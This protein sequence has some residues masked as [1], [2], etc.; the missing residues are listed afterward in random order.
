MAVGC[1]VA[2]IVEFLSGLMPHGLVYFKEIFH[3]NNHGRMLD[4]QAHQE[5]T[6]KLKQD[7]DSLGTQYIQLM[8][9]V[10]NLFDWRD[11]EQQNK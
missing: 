11:A 9:D 5:E 6:A 8:E 3:E 2:L 10:K 4:H 1:R 7:L